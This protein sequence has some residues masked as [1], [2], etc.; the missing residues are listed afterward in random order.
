MKKFKMDKNNLV[1]YIFFFAISF[2]KGIGMSNASKVYLAIYLIGIIFATIKLF[3]VGFN[4]KEILLLGSIF[5]IGVLDFIIGKETTILFTSITLLFLKSANLKSAI[6]AL[7]MGRVLGFLMMILLPLIGIIEMNE[8][9]FYR[10]GEFITRYAFGYSHPNL[11][12]STFD[13][14]VIMWLYL[15]NT[16]INLTSIAILEILNY[17]LYKY[18]VSRTGFFILA[19]FLLMAYVLKK[20]VKLKKYLP[21]YLNLIF[22]FLILFSALLAIGYGKNAIINKLD[23]VLTGRIRYTSILINNYMPPI[24]KNKDYTGILFDNGYFDL[25]YNGGL[26]AFIWF[27]SMQIKTNNIIRKKGLYNEALLS[28][29]FFICSFTESYYVSSLMNVSILF[30][31]YALYDEKIEI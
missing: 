2:C 3:K 12:H 9:N 23:V 5:L 19:V 20:R 1:V 13:I 26:L 8:L 7:F 17:I 25:I 4:Q 24:I 29:M 27:V 31:V 10:S 16:K 11:A 6:K 15:Y 18:T 28:L 22:I 21:K 14:I 30:I